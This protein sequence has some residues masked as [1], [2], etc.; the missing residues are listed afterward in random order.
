MSSNSTAELT[1]PSKAGRPR[2]FDVDTV[3]DKALLEF[4]TKGYDAASIGDL[5]DA[6]NIKRPSLYGT[7]GSKRELFLKVIQHYLSTHAHSPMIAM[8]ASQNIHEAV[9]SFLFVT[10]RET[11]KSSIDWPQGCFMSTTVAAAVGKV[12]GV[13]EVMC[14]AIARVEES[15]FNRFEQEKEAGNLPASFPSKERARLLFE[16]RQGYIL[17]VQTGQQDEY[18]RTDLQPRIASVLTSVPSL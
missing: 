13:R 14:A 3:L 18:E 2:Q 4:W 11:D 9:G 12:D 16:L 10:L 17:R 7:F 8:R 6:M 15:L 1:K 5:C